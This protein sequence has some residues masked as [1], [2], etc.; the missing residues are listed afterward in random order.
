MNMQSK[1]RCLLFVTIGALAA[2]GSDATDGPDAPTDNQ[3]AVDPAHFVAGGLKGAITTTSCTLS[4]GTT[5]TCYKIITVGAPSNRTVGPFCPTK[6]TD[7]SVAGMWIEGGK[8]YDL[9]GDFIANLATFYND[10]KWKLYDAAGNINVTNSQVACEA[11]ARPDVDPAYQNY[12]VECALSYYGGGVERTFLI[13]VNP[14]AR[15]SGTGSVGMG[16]VGVAFDG[17]VLDAP[18]PVA[19][20]KAAHT[21][22]AFDDCGGH[23]NAHAGYHYHAATGCSPSVTAADGHAAMIGYALDGYGMYALADASGAEPT[24]LDNCRG[25]SDS[26]RGYHYHVASA[27][28]NMFIGCF[29]GEQGTAN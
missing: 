17:I 16:G 1:Q 23:I 19:A 2:C 26:T 22:A 21:I 4:G 8:T 7:G 15:K 3:P 5:T 24:G 18:A 6:I 29:K 10:T 28:E 25:H 9:T 13:P 20:I 14:V 12:C 27:G 11:A